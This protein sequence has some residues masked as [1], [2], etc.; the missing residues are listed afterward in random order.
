[1][2][3]AAPSG[4]S[5]EL[6][7]RRFSLDLTTLPRYWFANNALLT[8]ALNAQN[9]FFPDA[10]RFFIRSVRKH[11][12]HVTDP[13]QRAEVK[14]FIG[15]EVQHGRS[16]DDV[17]DQLRAQGFR[18]DGWLSGYRGCMAMFERLAS[19]KL[20]LSVTAAVEHFTAS[21]AECWLT[22][23]RMPL[24]H[25]TMG[26]LLGWHAAEEIEHKAVAFDVLQQV[27]DRY[28]LRVVGMLLATLFLLMLLVGG[29][30]MLL[31][32]DPEATWR[33]VMDERA[34]ANADGIRATRFIERHMAPYLRRDFH[35]NDHDN[36]Q[37]ACDFLAQIA[38]RLK[39]SRPRPARQKTA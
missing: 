7:V 11:M 2:N 10:E 24:A 26:D 35:P 31:W 37:L 9:L 8:H 27:D 23:G 6:L 14:A 34:S 5:D 33:R 22:E 13:E 28:W 20:C 30:V 38:S 4:R 19:P 18:I 39:T 16:H 25:P 36:R 17:L 1:M 21:V 29:T 3:H 15:Q 12:D 32:Q